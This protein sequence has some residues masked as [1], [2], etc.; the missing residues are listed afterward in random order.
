VGAI[1]AL[2]LTGTELSIIALIGILLLI[3]S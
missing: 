3:A 1:L 2:L